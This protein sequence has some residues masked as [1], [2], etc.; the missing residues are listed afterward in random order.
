MG[1]VIPKNTRTKKKYLKVCK[2][3]GCE[4]EYMGLGVSKY[5][6]RHKDP[7]NRAKKGREP[8][9]HSKNAYIKHSYTSDVII[10]IACRHPGCP[11]R[12]RIRLQ[13]KQFI[14]PAMCE[15]H[16]T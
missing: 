15:R 5:C 8:G 6:D 9:D 7:R 12:F 4:R 1:I 16:R 3:P 10:E 14:Y 13:P 11:N 2:E